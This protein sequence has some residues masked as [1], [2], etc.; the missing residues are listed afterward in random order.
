MRQLL[1]YLLPAAALAG[2]HAQETLTIQDAIRKAWSGQSGLQA[3]E[4]M[5]DRAK[6]E[7][8]A[9][10]NLRLPTFSA[11][12]GLTRTDEPMMAF[13]TKLD[14]ARISMADFMPSSL[15]H[16]SAITG[17]GAFLSVTQPLYAGGRLDAAR[18]AG[19]AM[20]A[21]EGATQG[22]RRQQVALAIEQAYFGSQVA[23]QGLKWAEDTL[24]Q[25]QETERFVV[26]RAD[27]GLMLKSEGERA[28]AFRASAEA[29]VAEA[30][31]RLAS[32]RSAL[33][34]LMGSEPPAALATP[35]ETTEVAQATL[36]GSRGDVEALRA[37]GEAARQ[38]VVAAQGSF[39]P[40]VGATLL[41]GTDRYTWNSGG[42]W[43][44][45]SIGAKW[46]F[47][48]S[49]SPRVHAARAMARAA[50][51][52]LKWQQQQASR[53]VEEAKRGIETAQA[54]IAF[55]KVA[56]DASE[57]VRATRTARHREGLLPLVE[58]LDAESG[59][60]GA[61]TLLL[62]SQLEWRLS[63]AQLALALGQP[64]EGVKE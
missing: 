48:F 45:A 41:A 63:R 60:S 57:S 46:N 20:A 37:Q 24:R 29:G 7:A 33:A 31:Q 56:L 30:R 34:L 43:T 58:V 28:K 51:E 9:L 25:A 14:Q 19:A 12:V 27:Q 1:K 64:I 32:A 61:R 47:S 53:E 36:P 15:N 8:E 2:L 5:V 16:P 22:H 26:A 40:E 11:A 35:V 17:A 55:A 18:K 50:E 38:G 3:G 54:K 6:A 62:N 13:G 52:G 59:L 21:A 23:T 10:R 42:N 44:T 4:A 49:D 39:K